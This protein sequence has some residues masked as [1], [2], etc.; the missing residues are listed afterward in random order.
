MPA[1]NNNAGSRA[2]GAAEDDA[3]LEL[4]DEMGRSTYLG[5]H[6]IKACH[7]AVELGADAPA[8]RQP[9]RGY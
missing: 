8:R 3:L 6:Q 9:G 1:E 4:A 7:A 2:P 5:V